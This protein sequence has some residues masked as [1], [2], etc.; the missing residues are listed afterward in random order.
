[1]GLAARV[2]IFHVPGARQFDELNG[3]AGCFGCPRVAA[4]EIDGN[5]IIGA[6]MKYELSDAQGEHLHR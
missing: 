2:E 6:A 3:V 1:M 4:R 5:D